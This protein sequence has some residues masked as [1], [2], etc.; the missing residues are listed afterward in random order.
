MHWIDLRFFPAPSEVLKV[1]FEMVIT[2]E[3]WKHL[4]S[5]LYRVFAGFLIGSVS[6][7][8][9]GL[10]MGLS[11]WVRAIF[12]PIVSALYPIPKSALV[13]LFL[14]IFGLGETS[15]I[16]IVA[17]G[18]FFLV[19]INT[20]AGVLQVRRIHLD[21]GKNFGASRIRVLTTI[22]L[23]GSMPNIVAGLKLGMGMA[24]V[25]VVVAE[26]VGAESGIGYMIMN[27]WTIFAIEQMYAGLIITAVLGYVFTLLLD[28][29]ERFL[30]PWKSS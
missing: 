19:L 5:S 14:L 3:L 17:F 1:L 8:L 30:V 23:P 16:A 6:A 21:V 29:A 24:L 28:E 4:S 12:D 11:R 20:Q 26:M 13:P 25:V 7:I 18:V 27:A 9:L 15:K 10:V 22:A 2:G